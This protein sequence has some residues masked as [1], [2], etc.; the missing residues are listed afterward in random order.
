MTLFLEYMMTSYYL[1]CKKLLVEL[2]DDELNTL[3]SSID[4]RYKFMVD[5]RQDTLRDKIDERFD[6]YE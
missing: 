4:I 5:I 3:L 6:A 2:P 1:D